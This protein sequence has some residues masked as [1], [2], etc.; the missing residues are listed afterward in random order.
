LYGFGLGREHFAKVYLPHARNS[1]A[2]NFNTPGPGH[3]TSLY[4]N[5]GVQSR[6]T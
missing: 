2:P 4:H 3:Y 5:V 6:K 1:A